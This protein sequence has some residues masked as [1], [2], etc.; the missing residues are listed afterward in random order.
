VLHPN[1]PSDV[2][3][4]I[5]PKSITFDKVCR[6]LARRASVGPV[7]HPADESHI[8]E[9]AQTDCGFFITQDKRVLEKR[10]ELKPMLPPSLAIVTLEELFEILDEYGAKDTA[11]R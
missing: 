7:K 4:T 11:G 5:L 8:C 3:A 9:A 1:T 2:R 6:Q 10:V